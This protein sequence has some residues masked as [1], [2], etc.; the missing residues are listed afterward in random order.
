MDNIILV[1]DSYKVWFSRHPS[2][3]SIRM[4]LTF[5]EFVVPHILVLSLET[6]S[7]RNNEIVLLFWITW[8]EIRQDCLLW[9]AIH[10]QEMAG[11]KGGHRRKDPRSQGVCWDAL[12]LE[13]SLQRGGLE[14]HIERAS[15][16]SPSSY[17]SSSRRLSHSIPQC[18]LY[19]R[20]YWSQSP[21]AH[22]LARNFIFASL[23][24]F[25]SGHLVSLPQ[26]NIST[27]SC[28]DGRWRCRK[29]NPILAIAWFWLPRMFLCG[30]M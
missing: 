26:R 19:R 28:G 18:A 27:V 12:R 25:N 24:S 6:I 1:T 11:R 9:L 30:G 3:L 16:S 14:A 10:H 21:L 5:N 22:K 29:V 2:L 4:I 13:K 7:T 20:K 23:V 8:W 17:Q 15:R